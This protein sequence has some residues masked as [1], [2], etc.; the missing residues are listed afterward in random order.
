MKHKSERYKSR[1]ITPWDDQ[2]EKI[3]TQEFVIKVTM[4]HYDQRHPEL[5]E[6]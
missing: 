2:D 5:S 4:K 3:P 1:R 6:T